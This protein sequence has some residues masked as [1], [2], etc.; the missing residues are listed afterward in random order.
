MRTLDPIIVIFLTFCLSFAYLRGF[1]YGI[2]RYQLNNSAYKKKKN[3]ETFTE[4]ILYSRY[5]Q[6]IPK[7]LRVFYYFVL[8]IHSVSILICAILCFT[9]YS[10]NIGMPIAKAIYYF[11]AG[12]AILIAFLFW[13]PKKRS[14][15]PYARWIT[16]TRGQKG[17]NKRSKT[18]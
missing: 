10:S 2:K 6:E 8:I 7:L 11:D 18:G 5:T 16:K 15:Y 9:K 1:L 13:S 14:D 4:W 3:G 17:K 12:W